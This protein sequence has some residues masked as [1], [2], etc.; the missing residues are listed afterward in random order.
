MCLKQEFLS[1]ECIKLIHLGVLDFDE[2][3]LQ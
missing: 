1:T 3:W 2:V